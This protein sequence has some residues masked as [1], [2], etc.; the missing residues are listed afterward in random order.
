MSVAAPRERRRARS[1]RR[2]P[3][4]SSRCSGPRA[5]RTRRRRRSRFDVARDRADGPPGLHDRAHDADHDRAGAAR[6]R[7][8]EARAAASS[9][10]GPPERWAATTRSLVWAQPTCSCRRFT[11]S[12][13]FAIPSPCTYDL[14][15][16][17]AKY[18]DALLGR[19]GAARASTSTARSS[20]A[21]TTAACRSRRCRGAARSASGCRSRCG[22]E[23]IERAT[24]RP[25][26]GS[27]CA[28]HDARARSRAP[29]RARRCRRSTRR[30]RAARGGSR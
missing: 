20:T 22:G 11:G 16:A 1:R 19:R 27:R 17:A 9:L 10:F 30:R 14:E 3:S 18:F 24:T 15:V 29:A 12:T 23:M 2:S 8:R 25:R 7:R 5:V 21:A 28:S 13:T 6:L 4:P 26:A